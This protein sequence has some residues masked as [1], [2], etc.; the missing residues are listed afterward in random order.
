VHIIQRQIVAEILGI[1]PDSVR[2]EVGDT[3]HA[4]YHDGIKGQGATHTIGQA[5]ARAATALIE[6][7]QARAAR[8]WD[9]DPAGLQWRD[10]RAWLSGSRESLDLVEL[11]RLAPHEPGRGYYFYNAPRRPHEHIFQA[12]IANVEIDPET[13]Q[14]EIRDI[15]SF[16]DVSV[17]INPLTHQG[18]I[19]GGLIQGLGM[20]L[21]EEMVV[22]D[23]RVSTLNL[24]EY[25]IPS[26]RDIPS[27]K[28]ILVDDATHGPGPFNAKA[29]AEH[30]ITPVPPAVANAV[31]D[32]T[33]IRIMELPITA[34]RLLSA[35]KT[36]AAESEECA[37]LTRSKC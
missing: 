2:V 22:R 23:G 28:T 20:A 21:S 14:V 24:G 34:E 26:I 9:V 30:S 36:Q 10:G 25:K 1:N 11:A 15:S 29:A 4:P 18:Q 37:A 33:G 35:L 19:D 12:E 27:H 16:H 31:F 13:G 7:L 32:A 8:H 17:V 3:N 5:V 6:T